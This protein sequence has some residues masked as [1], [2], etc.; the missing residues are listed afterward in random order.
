[1][2]GLL[3]RFVRDPQV[4]SVKIKIKKQTVKKGEKP[5]VNLFLSPHNDDEALFGAYI[6]QTWKPLVL[7]V[8][9][10]Y[11][12]PERGEKNC[13]KETRIAE[14]IA[15]MKI[16]GAQIDFLHIPDKSFN[17]DILSAALQN[18][19]QGIDI[20]FAPAIEG[21]NPIHDV[22]GRVADRLFSNVKHYSTY[23][24]TRLYPEGSEKVE[25]SEFMKALKIQALACYRSQITLGTTSIF[26][27]T[28]HK[29]E[30][31]CS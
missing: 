27:T 23:S 1:M 16:L 4:K 31:L 30:Y 2:A 6:I 26:F 10:S 22:V 15:A 5:Q 28:S 17:E 14:S 13:D 18:Y 29:D 21:G 3:E 24:K 7:I 20:A 25:S 11:I 12:Q 8:T 19:K 9:D